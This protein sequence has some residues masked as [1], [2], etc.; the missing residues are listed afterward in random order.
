MITIE[1]TISCF[2]ITAV[3]LFALPGIVLAQD[4]PSECVELGALAYDS[5]ISEDAGGSGLPNGETDNDYLRCKSCHG[6]DQL[7]TNGGYVRRSRNLGRPNAGAGD[8]DQT[9]RDISF[10]GREGEPITAA[11]IFHAGTGRSLEDGSGSW[12][13]LDDPASPANKAAHSAGY[14]LGNQHPD[15]STGGANG[16]AQQQADCLAE[17]LNFAD[18]GWDAYFDEINPDANPVLYT[19]RG[20]SDATRGETFYASVCFDCHGNPAEVG[21]PFPIE[22]EGILDFLADTPHFSEFYNKVRWGHPGSIMTRAALGNPTALDVAD[23]MLYLQQLGGTGFAING[24]ISGTW[25]GGPDRDG[26]GWLIDSANAFVAAFY[27]YNDVGDTVWVLGNGQPDGNMVT[28]DLEIPVPP[29]PSFGMNY[30]ASNKNT[31]PFGTARF[32]FTSCT[33]GQVDIVP[34]QAMIDQGFEEITIQLS[35]L[36]S[37]EI[38]C[39]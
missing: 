25:W 39:P 17:F 30:D 14:T 16:L 24:G 33:M 27:T 7:G 13:P 2:A 21:S 19:I 3:L 10:S 11:M 1:R 12:V 6:W 36:T 32:T 29:G 26:E 5:W 35:R 28:V 31:V 20:D 8:I 4:Q 22:G 15:F 38:S 18:A 37:P 9:S 23:V 34:N